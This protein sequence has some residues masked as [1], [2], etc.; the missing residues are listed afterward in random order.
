MGATYARDRQIMITLLLF[1]AA[2]IFLALLSIYGVLSQRVRERSREI[3]IRMAKGAKGATVLG[4][5]AA[6]GLRLIAVGLVTTMLVAV[7]IGI[8]G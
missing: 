5:V 1:A 8:D 4:W 7:A 6:S 3:G 2:A